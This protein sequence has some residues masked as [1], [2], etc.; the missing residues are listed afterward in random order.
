MNFSRKPCWISKAQLLDFKG[1]IVGF[2]RPNFWLFWARREG[3]FS[4]WID[5]PCRFAA[6]NDEISKKNTYI[7]HIPS[8]KNMP[9]LCFSSFLS[10]PF[11]IFQTSNLQNQR[12]SGI[13]VVELTTP[14]GYTSG[15]CVNAGEVPD[16]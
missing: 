3:I 6:E 15:G 9:N 12:F 2:Q 11:S 5:V 16:F 4:F 8:T 10:R 14:V 1:P 7:I 13:A